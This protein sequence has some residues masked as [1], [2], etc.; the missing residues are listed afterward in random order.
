M[1]GAMARWE[2]PDKAVCSL[3]GSPLQLQRQSPRSWTS[4]LRVVGSS[5]P[6]MS[7][8]YMTGSL[9]NRG[10]S[11]DLRTSQS[12]RSPALDTCATLLGA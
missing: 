2:L 3:V 5:W 8:S 7:M 1:S 9:R 10:C 11:I 6:P 12:A 4:A